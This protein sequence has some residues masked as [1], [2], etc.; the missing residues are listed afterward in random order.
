MNFD[1]LNKLF[2]DAYPD[3]SDFFSHD[4]QHGFTVSIVM[5][6]TGEGNYIKAYNKF[7]TEHWKREEVKK[8]TP[9]P[10]QQK[11]PVISLDK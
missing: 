9:A 10:I 3:V 2:P 11:K 6:L 5:G 1:V 7:I 4:P 8:D